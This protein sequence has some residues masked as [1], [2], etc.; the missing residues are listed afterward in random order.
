MGIVIAAYL[1]TVIADD[2]LY[3]I[4]MQQVFGLLCILYWYVAQII[5]PIGYV[6]GKQRTKHLEFARRAIGVSAAYFALLH[7]GIAL[8]GQLGGLSQIALLPTLF[9][10][11]LAGGAL[12]L[13]ILLVMAATSF[14]KVVKFMTFKRW[15]WLHRLV[16]AGLIIVVLHIWSIGTHLA[17]SN[18]QI[19]AFVALVILSGLE[20]FR[21]VKIISDKRPEFKSKDY[22]VTLFVGIWAA[23]I[24]LIASIPALISNYHSAH[25][26][27]SQT[28][29][30]KG[31]H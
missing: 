22:F 2:Q 24:I 5:S 8:W 26:D 16:Y 10:W 29:Q 7:A 31:M 1:R 6:I 19:A 18:I 13:L 30:H 28:S 17:Y 14:D 27:D 15:K 9:Q 21:V 11:S 20:T 4:R 25:T 23:W 3:Y 12:A